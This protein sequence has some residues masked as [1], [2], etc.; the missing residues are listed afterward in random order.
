MK[1]YL[2]YIF[3]LFTFFVH[4]RA[5]S[6]SHEVA[7]K[8]FEEGRLAEEAEDYAKAADL[9]E[10]AAIAE[11]ASSAPRL[12]K[13]YVVLGKA[14]S[15][16]WNIG[17]KEKAIALQNESLENVEKALGKEHAEYRDYLKDLALLYTYIGQYDKAL[18]LSLEGLENTEK[19][20]GKDHYEY[21]FSLGNL[22]N[23][24]VEMGQY[25]K[26]LPFSLEALEN[27]EKVFGKDHFLYGSCLNSLA[28]VYT[29]MGQY[30]KALPFSLGA[31]E[32]T[33]KVFGKDHGYYGDRL[34]NLANLY[35]RMGQYDK[36]LPLSLEVLVST[37][38]AL[39][40]DHYEYGS[41]LSDLANVYVGM[42]QYDKA[43]PLSLEALGNAEK[44]LGKD[45]YEYGRRL[46]DLANIYARM[47]QYD[48]ALSLS[49]E[50]L[51]NAEKA[52][53][54]DHS[55]YR[56][57][58]F[59]LAD[60]YVRMGQY[61]KALPLSLEVLEKDKRALGKDHVDYGSSL[62][63]LA[64]L[65]YTMGLHDKALPLYLESLENTE[66]ALGKDHAA[67]GGLLNDL[68]NLYLS[69][70]LYDKT[71]RM[72]LYDKALSLYLEAL[73]NTEKTLGK[74]HAFYGNRLNNLAIS[75]YRMG[76]YGKALPLALEALEN[77]KKALGKGH[78]EYGDIL[79]NLA[80]LYSRMGQNDKA[81]PLY[82]ESL[83]NTEKALGKDHDDYEVRLN[84]LANTYAGMGQYNKALPLYLEANENINRQLNL[85][86]S[87]LSEQEKEN[88]IRK[89]G[90]NF[91][92]YQSFFTQY[93]S[94]NPDVSEPAYNIEL[95]TKGLILT[96][97]RQMRSAIEESGNAEALR[98]YE[99]WSMK[100][101]GLARQYAKPVSERSSELK[102]WEEEAENV[103]KQLIQLSATFKENKQLGKTNWKDIQAALGPHETA[104]EFASF[105]YKNDKISTDS[106]LYTALI[107]KKGY[108]RPV[109]VR[110]FEQRQ[111]DSL[112]VSGS[113][114]ARVAGLY[115]GSEGKS[116][117]ENHKKL[118]DLVW[119]PLEAHIKEKK[120]VYFAPSGSLHQIAFSAIVT[121]DGQYLS[122]KYR[123][124]QVS[125]T[126]K[127]L[128]GHKTGELKDITLFGGIDYAA[129]SKDL[130]VQAEQIKNDAVV[131]RSLTTDLKRGT[132]SWDYLP[133][134]RDEVEALKGISEKAGVSVNY[135]TGKTAVEER[136]KQ[137]NRKASPTILHVATHGFFFPDP[138]KKYREERFLLEQEKNV[139]KLSDNPLNRSGLLFSGAN[140]AWKG[141]PVTEGLEDGILTAYEA[142]HVSLPNTKL[143]VLSACETGLGDIKGSEGV[144][145]L[146]RAFKLA[147]AEYLLMS[148]WKVPDQETAEFMIRF[149]ELL[150]STKDIPESYRETQRYMKA[151]YPKEPYKWAAFVLVR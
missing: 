111:L 65:Y 110:L 142:S 82:L 19:A 141:E 97:S 18:P 37:E 98:L 145:G 40:K 73:K 133:G 90:F 87:F 113:D 86:F 79:N 120:T 85:T 50:A 80:N 1:L 34:N 41:R 149:Y 76:Q 96:S 117:G 128:Q 64:N 67:Y 144:F 32:N 57:C 31:L 60:V 61:D 24:Y 151:K 134:T 122:D 146:Q 100:K 132:S 62:H 91:E 75:Y 12:E 42:S 124:Q 66:K 93:G 71:L 47:G 88:F 52:L 138:E 20:S 135:F 11:K 94:E 25:N 27:A 99:E 23:V 28:N 63:N 45:N 39:G 44:A 129:D 35:Y 140:M 54:K 70:G 105:Q 59:S 108:E 36:A 118:Y 29:G 143:V 10:K 114:A 130:L 68:A 107:L 102:R 4:D 137:Q 38:K 56:S 55:D 51:E 109:L 3:F 116:T 6:Q 49:L 5:Y 106:T 125:T 104:I 72:S 81:L 131:S 84:N 46:S 30:N 92:V 8:Y 21:G 69:I 2:K 103:E 123:L 139:Y 7:D 148:L 136:F 13:L 74:D 14:S 112:R 78:S 115:R 119:K 33:E 126:A 147:G 89:I 43:L 58:L 83:E 15:C 26:A 95:L 127:I 16:F 9:Y 77:A 22:A 101:S 17:N 48:K 121:P 150:F 53:G